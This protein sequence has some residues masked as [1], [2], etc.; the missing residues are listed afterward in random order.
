MVKLEKR[1]EL[2]EAGEE[3]DWSIPVAK[4]E[5]VLTDGDE[6][7]VAYHR[8][9]DENGLEPHQI[10]D[11]LKG[12]A[13]W[14]QTA[15]GGPVPMLKVLP[16][17][18]QPGGG[19]RQ[20]RVAMRLED[21]EMLRT[22]LATARPI[23]LCRRLGFG[24]EEGNRVGSVTEYLVAQGLVTPAGQPYS[25]SGYRFHPEE[26]DR[27]YQALVVKPFLEQL[28]RGGAQP[29]ATLSSKLKAEP[30][31]RTRTG[32]GG[33]RPAQRKE[34]VERCLESLKADGLVRKLRN[35]SWELTPQDDTHPE[36][37]SNE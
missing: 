30:I 9:A 3:P 12:K 21:L 15:I 35:G 23:D 31:F 13:V 27:A 34:Q 5:P 10:H 37:D 36:G 1:A 14:L 25:I 20:L 29:V 33:R 19:G 6:G 8:F 11:A 32:D 26:V 28:K 16:L 7:W 4:K 24:E 17:D 2:I 22:Y 18:H